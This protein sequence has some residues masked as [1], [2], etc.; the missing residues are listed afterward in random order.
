MTESFFTDPRVADLRAQI[1]SAILGEARWEDFL[2]SLCGVLPNGAATLFYHDTS[3]VRGAFALA[4]G[5]DPTSLEAYAEHYC[6]LNPWM[7]AATRR[8]IGLS[9]PDGAMFD[10]R[11]LVKT[12]FYNDFLRPNNLEG[13]IGVTLTRKEDCHFFLSVLGDVQETEAERA[14]LRTLRALVPDLRR[15]FEFYQRSAATGLPG[16]QGSD[17]GTMVLGPRRR[18]RSSSGEATRQLELGRVMSVGPTGRV[19]FKDGR[20]ARHIDDCLASAHKRTA[21]PAPRAILA[22]DPSGAPLRL[23]VMTWPWA[24]GMRYFRG[25]EC[26][27]LVEATGWSAGDIAEF[28]RLYGLTPRETD[29]AYALLTGLAPHEIAAGLGVSLETVRSHIR[30]I[31]AKTGTSRQPHLVSLIGRCASR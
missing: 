7:Q 11:E 18:L 25:P 24:D 2:G 20:I 12:E 9:V 15:A 28:A 22:A 3:V 19:D 29:T 1:M 6:A 27:V 14:A 5:I 31:F 30:A 13:A 4:A 8:P 10:R 17:I 21:G 26:L 16:P 23:S